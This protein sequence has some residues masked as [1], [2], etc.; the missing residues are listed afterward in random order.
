MVVIGRSIQIHAHA[1]QIKEAVGVDKIRYQEPYVGGQFGIKA[2]ISTEC[3]AAVAAV[4]FKRPIR[5]I[6]SLTESMWISCKRHPF[7]MKVKLGADAS[8]HITGYT[9]EFMVD[10]GAYF[11]LGF[12]VP[13]RALHMINGPYNIPNLYALGK[14]AYTNN[15]SGGAARGAGPPQVAFALECAMDMLAEKMGMDPL[16]FRQINSMKPGDTLPTGPA[17]QQWPFPELCDAIRPAYEQAKKDAAAHKDGVIKRGVGIGCDSFGIGE[18]G[19]MGDV[20]VE[21]DPDNGIT[22]YAA[23][24]DPGEGNDSMLTQIAAHMLNLPMEKVRLYTR[25][26]DKTVNMR[27]GCRKPHDLYRRRRPGKRY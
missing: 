20:T 1:A 12:I 6:P 7:Y 17:V 3:L 27:T 22:I 24:A 4:Y 21:L 13:E 15:A 14:L 11:L 19:D 8:G 16:K 10:K 26:T 23:V 2:T 18:S 25:D 9:N 5:Y